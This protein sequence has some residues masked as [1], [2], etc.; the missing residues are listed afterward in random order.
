MKSPIRIFLCSGERIYINGAVLRVDRKVTLELINDVMFLL[1]NQVMQAA[2]ATTPLR[3][4]YFMV[5]LMLMSPSEAHQLD[6]AYQQ[7]L[8][9]IL[10]VSENDCLKSGLREVEV[11]VGANR[12]YDAL[13]RI[14]TL[15]PIEQD[16]LNGT[17]PDLAAK[18]A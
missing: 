14:R 18:T 1:E 7:H 12:Y 6:A 10:I 2:D 11:L 3:Q 4:L 17:G 13:K 9:A 5:Q 15:Y 16:I 8:D